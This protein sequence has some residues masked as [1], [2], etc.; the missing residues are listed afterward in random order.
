MNK[1]IKKTLK[2][3]LDVCF[4]NNSSLA[5]NK[6]SREIG[7]HIRNWLQDSKIENIHRKSNIF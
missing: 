7:N 3:E 1:Q 2:I 6:N 4:L 5:G